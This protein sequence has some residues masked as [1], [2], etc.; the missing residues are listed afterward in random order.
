VVRR[1]QSGKGRF[2][3]EPLSLS[4]LVREISPLI[5]TSIPKTV[6]VRLELQ[7]Q[8]PLVAGDASQLQQLIM[9][10]VIN[11]AEAIPEGAEGTVLVRTSVQDV[12]TTYIR[13][14][15]LP[16]ELAPGDYAVLEV[17]D[18][19]TG[20]DAATRERMFDPFF[21]TKFTGRG[22]GLAAALGIVR[23]HQGALKLYSTPGAGTTFKVLFPITRDQPRERVL[24][25]AST[26][27]GAAGSILV[28][29]DEEI[30]RNLA[31]A[32]LRRQ[33][34]TVLVAKDGTEGVAVY[35]AYAQQIGVVVLDL[36]MPGVSGEE[37]LRRL[38]DFRP[39]VRVVLSTGYNE[40]A[41][42]QRFAGKGLAGFLQ[43]PYSAASLVAAVEDAV[44]K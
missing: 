27:R 18:T 7:E 9:N 38:K 36:T 34:F 11:G 10:L 40:V 39:D 16:E 13:N 44:A 15:V 14:T 5:R 6:Q 3:I 31:T 29:D 2:V 21:T 37:T 23:S 24:S 22:L 17:H 19:G 20:I 43:K 4:A 28:I 32:V 1:S 30:V 41:V 26:E 35:R 8:L 12:D 33:G 25:R 42:L